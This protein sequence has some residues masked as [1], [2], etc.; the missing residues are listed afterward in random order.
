VTGEPDRDAVAGMRARVDDAYAT[1]DRLFR[2]ADRAARTAAGEVPPSGW[3]SPGS[4]TPAEER[5]PDV[6]AMLALLEGVRHA[7]PPELSRRLAGALREL[8]L[9]LRALLDW[10]L[11]RLDARGTAP[12]QVRDIPID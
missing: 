5:G 10:W 7:V 6:A 9:A 12:V 1:A 2:E 11:E 8:L 3:A 4:G